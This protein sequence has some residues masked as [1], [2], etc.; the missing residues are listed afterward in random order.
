M[1]ER[2]EQIWKATSSA[3]L[4]L[5]GGDPFADLIA[6]AE[7]H[8]IVHGEACGLYP[9][10]PLVMKLVRMFARACAASRILDLGA[11]LGYSTLWL[12]STAEDAE[13]TAVDRFE[14][15]VTLARRFAERA[16][17]CHRVHFIQ[18]G[19]AE[20]LPGLNTTFDL[21]HDDGWFAREP[22]YLEGML[23]LLRPGG[24]LTM[25]NWFLL[26]D[27]IIELPRQD[28]VGHAGP[29]WAAETLEY[30]KRLAS[31]PQLEGM[32]SVSPPLGIRIKRS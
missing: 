5:I 20:V 31:H 12:A 28:R 25:P 26:E 30:A 27:A 19:V 32:W 9:A 22:P 3:L 14:E 6:A 11:G 18:G 7:E 21:I 4:E 17:V 10:G 1:I 2:L 29:E 24:V 13:V 8:R 23:R 15:H 16:G